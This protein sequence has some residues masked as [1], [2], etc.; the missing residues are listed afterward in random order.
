MRTLTLVRGL[1]IM[2]MLV[3]LAASD[4]SVVWAQAPIRVRV[5]RSTP[6]QERARGDSLVIGNLSADVVVAFRQQIGRWVEVEPL[7][8]D[9]PSTVPQGRGWVPVTHLA[10]LDQRPG[11]APARRGEFMIR[12]FGHVGETLFTASNSFEA[13]FGAS[14]ALTLGGGAQV[15]LPSGLFVQGAVDRSSKTGARVIASNQQLFRTAVSDTVR[16]T[17]VEFT[18]GYREA[19]SNRAI[20]YVGAGAGWQSLTEQSPSLAT[21][22]RSRKASMHL[23]GGAEYR[24][25]R[26]LWLAGEV[27]WTAVPKGLDAGGIGGVFSETDRGGTSF[28]LKVLVGR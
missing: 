1:R 8:G 12:A 23:L 26:M 25:S 16:L 10:F 22:V 20:G 27:N 9:P 5:T 6:V 7:P 4:S 13:L 28:R 15:V 19:R 24:V 14:H 21:D 3:L 2:W 11:A 18:V 17:P